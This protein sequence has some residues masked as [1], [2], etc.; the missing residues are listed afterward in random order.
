MKEIFEFELPAITAEADYDQIKDSLK[1]GLSAI[2]TAETA[3][4]DGVQVGDVIVIPGIVEK[5]MSIVNDAEEFV[6]EFVKIDG[7]IAV[8]AIRESADELVSEGKVFGKVSQFTINVLFALATTYQIAEDTY[9]RSLGQYEM[10][11][12]LFAG[13]NVMPEFFA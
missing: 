4:Q 10:F 1:K 2:I 5:I 11:K 3:L 9:K 7:V 8:Q 6:Q 13:K 12:D